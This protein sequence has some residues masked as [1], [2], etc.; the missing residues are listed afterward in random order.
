MTLLDVLAQEKDQ[1]LIVGSIGDRRAIQSDEVFLR[2]TFINV[3]DSAIKFTRLGGTIEVQARGVPS[4]EWKSP[5]TI[6]AQASQKRA[7]RRCLSVFTVCHR[8]RPARDSD[9]QSPS[10]SSKLITAQSR[11]A[12]AHREALGSRSGLQTICWKTMHMGIR[13]PIMSPDLQEPKRRDK[14][15][16]TGSAE[17]RQSQLRPERAQSRSLPMQR[18]GQHRALNLGWGRGCLLLLL[19]L[20]HLLSLF[21]HTLHVTDHFLRALALTRCITRSGRR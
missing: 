7:R 2:Y 18:R 3:I 19:S 6:K 8:A 5:C 12:P 21:V 9:S 13:K 17:R 14:E 10:G 20:G 16:R 4:M 11:S 15:P 1:V